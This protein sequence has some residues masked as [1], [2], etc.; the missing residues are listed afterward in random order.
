MRGLFTRDEQAVVLF[1]TIALLVGSAVQLARRVDPGIASEL[2]VPE[3]AAG[4]RSAEPVVW[5]LDLNEADATA[6]DRLPG[7]GPA[8]ARAILDLRGRLGAFRSVDDLIEVRGIGPK[9]LE[10]IRPLAVVDTAVTHG[11]RGDSGDGAAG[12]A[13]KRRGQSGVPNGE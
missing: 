6:L 9:T 10:A 2:S 3:T 8:R 13:T 1:L 11:S 5:P 12:H 4:E 7:I